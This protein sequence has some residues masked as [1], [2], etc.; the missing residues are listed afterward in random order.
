MKIT[1]NN[2]RGFYA[3]IA[4]MVHAGLTF[5]ADADALVITLTGGY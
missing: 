3:G 1:Y 4:A 5:E 2:A